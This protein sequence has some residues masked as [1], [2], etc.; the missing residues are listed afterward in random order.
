MRIVVNHKRKRGPV[1]GDFNRIFDPQYY[2]AMIGI[3]SKA[4]C[5]LRARPI[6]AEALRVWA[7]KSTATKG[8]YAVTST[9][10]DFH[11]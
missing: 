3:P 11:N 5:V 8:L 7:S 9:H 4:T 2:L 1:G 6:L 10:L